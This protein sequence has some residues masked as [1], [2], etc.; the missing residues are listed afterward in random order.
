MS[1]IEKLLRILSAGHCCGTYMNFS[2]STG[3]F[4]L[5]GLEI[6]SFLISFLQRASVC[7]SQ[8]VL[9]GDF[10]A[11]KICGPVVLPLDTIQYPCESHQGPLNTHGCGFRAESRIMQVVKCNKP[12]PC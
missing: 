6:F 9:Y 4:G 7:Q 5:R 8:H 12:Y 11:S 1:S 10:C 3:G 2:V